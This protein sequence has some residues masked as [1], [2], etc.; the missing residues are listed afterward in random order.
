MLQHNDIPDRL[1]FFTVNAL[2]NAPSCIIEESSI[3]L[4]LII[5]YSNFLFIAFDPVMSPHNILTFFHLQTLL[6]N[7]SDVIENF[8]L[9][10][11]AEKMADINKISYVMP[12]LIPVPIFLPWDVSDQ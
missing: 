1:S 9:F 10:K 5:R 4:D 2:L 3:H 7:H 11:M 8:E 12:Q 6:I